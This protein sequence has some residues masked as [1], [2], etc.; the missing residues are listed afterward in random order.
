[1]KR[2]LAEFIIEGVK[3]TIPF[4][5]S[6]LSKRQFLRGNVTTSFIDNNGIIEELK[7]IKPKKEILP[8][9]KKILIVTTAVAQ[10]LAKKQQSSINK[11]INP[12]ITAARQESMSEGSLEE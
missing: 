5:Q 1:M 6:V 3:T 2:A 11:K 12:W 9:E 8:K 4:H 7:E 10:Y